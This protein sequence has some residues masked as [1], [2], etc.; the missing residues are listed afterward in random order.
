MTEAA[1]S[2]GSWELLDELG[3]LVVERAPTEAKI[4]AEFAKRNQETE[5]GYERATRRAAKRY[6]TRKSAIESQ[7]TAA[8]EAATAKF[9]AQVTA[10]DRE[11]EE[12]RQAATEQFQIDEENAL[13][14]LQ[15]ARWQAGT[16][17][18]AG[19][20]N[21]DNNFKELQ[22]QLEAQNNVFQGF[23]EAAQH[24]LRRRWQ[25]RN[26][27][28][29]ETIAPRASGQP[30]RPFPELT[31]LARDQLRALAL[32]KIP[33]YFQGLGPLALLGIVALAVVLPA[34]WLA[35]WHS[36][37]WLV[38][39]VTL[40]VVA[41]FV[42]F[43][44]LFRIAR[45]QTARAYVALQQT[46]LEA[47][48]VRRLAFE[49]G[50]QARDRQ[51]AA[52]L[53]EKKSGLQSAD[54]VF[55]VQH[56]A[57]EQQ[58]DRALADAEHHHAERTAE[59]TAQR[60]RQLHEAELVRTRKLARLEAKYSAHVELLRD[61]HARRMQESQRQFDEQWRD[62]AERWNSGMAHFQSASEQLDGACKQLFHDWDSQP[63][64]HWTPPTEIPPA[65]PFGRFDLHLTEVKG[66]LPQDSRLHPTKTDF[67]LPVLFPCRHRPLLLFKTGADGQGP[68]VA[69]MQALMLRMLVSLP[70]GK[71]RFM[72]VDPV[73]LG[74]HFS[75]FMHLVDFNEQLVSSRIWTDP[76]HIEQRLAE[77]TGHMENV[78]QVYLRNEFPSIEEYNR[79]AGDLAE[80]YR[81]LVV[82]NFPSGFSE[83][84][85]ARLQSIVSSG[86][87]CGVY[88]VMSV[89]SRQRM[90]RDFQLA[91]LERQAIGLSWNDGG[92]AWEHAQFGKLPLQMLSP[93]A[94]PQFTEIVRAVGR[95]VK[96]ADR[97][98]V[99]F[100]CIAPQSDKRWTAD[101]SRGIDVPLGR[102]GAMK[103]Q[104]LEL[105]HGTSQHVLI[106]GK[107]GS[108][109]STLLHVLITNLALRYSPDEIELYLV[110]FK[111]GVEFKAY[112]QA[113]LPHAR[114]IAIESEREFG[115]SVLER[116]DQEL[117][118]RGD[119]FRRENVQ[120][121]AAYR[122]A[123]PQ[124]R[125][126]RVLL[127]VDEFQELFT[128]DDRIAQNSA[129]LLDRLVR[130]GRAFGIHVLLGSQTL[131]GAYS[132]PRSTIGQMAVRIALQCSEADAHLILSEENTAARLLGRPGEAIYND[133]NGLFEGNH[134]FQITWL[135]DEERAEWLEQVAELHR[136]RPSGAPPA[137]VF[138]GNTPADP[139]ANPLM[140]ELL[141][142]SAWPEPG[143]TARGWLGAAVA[144]KDPTSVNF[145][146]QGGNNLLVV[147]H[148]EEAARG[149][150]ASCLL[151]LAVQHAPVETN[152]SEP[153]TQ[154]H[155][156][157]GTRPDAPAP[158]FWPRVA[159]ALPHKIHI[160]GPREAGAVVA[161]LAAELG[162]REQEHAD[163]DPPV[164]LMIFDLARFRELRKS[165]DDFSYSRL[166]DDKPVSASAHLG[167]LLR[168]GPA[169]GIHVLIWCDSYHNVGRF[170]ER[171]T[172]RDLELRVLFQMNV[173]DSSN[174]VDSPAASQLGIHRALLYDEG[175]GFLEKFRPYG[176]PGD[177]WLEQ[178]GQQLRSRS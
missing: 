146:R 114:V 167:R 58:R 154:F 94:G 16:L 71:V 172:L 124:D 4:L 25:W 112:A 103:F 65:V 3:R 138:E 61:N 99:P 137:I 38:F 23:A 18:E 171:Q 57:L 54:D 13:D 10:V 163:S 52:L 97:V 115:L 128:E 134:P 62:V 121:V 102:A 29:V 26:R 148:Q 95:E 118:R 44:V 81:V 41:T 14:D 47:D 144:I 149:V 22:S 168:D 158:D 11:H 31:A 35:G 85:A 133:A 55:S 27:P 177:D 120:D 176:P 101:S 50:R 53:T 117:K 125:L 173:T 119:M 145:T 160:A 109:K 141:S 19:T 131:A 17:C 87:R 155:I 21:V 20:G 106:A 152:G 40:D 122:A 159:H 157:D 151:S 2:E 73:G 89:D 165:D 161:Q 46:L 48:L 96:D 143:P 39:G 8:V 123:Q 91:D 153:A 79:F 80:P 1:W 113:N 72:I 129:L 43:T 126:P 84:A 111:K 127:I 74:E 5:R 68:A 60:D 28:Q 135:P 116:L 130:Q 30:L 98:Q 142:A 64:D 83:V 45:R 162:R 75:A 164:Y 156:L 174:L 88:T 93:P 150:L 66:G 6:E 175:E 108:G 76:S 170:M 110:D 9:Q 100:E 37:R 147:G 136:Q 33:A 139:R 42:T 166:D 15:E 169:L 178:I 140:G 24:I 105:G 63:W 49:T 78:I 90:P 77:L 59:I 86:A 34:G 7:Y 32:Q 56:A 104:S 36:K 107:T 92:F 70:P 132:L 82:A 69:S 67:V 12:A 51:L